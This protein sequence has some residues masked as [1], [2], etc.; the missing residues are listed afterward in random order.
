MA[1][2]GVEQEDT[3]FVRIPN[4]LHIRYAYLSENLLDE[5]L[6]NGNVEVVEYAAE[7]EF[8]EDGYFARFESKCEDQTVAA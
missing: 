8:H 3:R 2:W 1:K 7:I 6:A 4:A 5:A